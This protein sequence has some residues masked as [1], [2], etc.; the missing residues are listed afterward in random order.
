MTFAQALAID[1]GDIASDK[2]ILLQSPHAR[3]YRCLGEADPRP[4]FCHRKSSIFGKRCQDVAVDA[5]QLIF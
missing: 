3:L 2:A 4:Q 5:V 1:D